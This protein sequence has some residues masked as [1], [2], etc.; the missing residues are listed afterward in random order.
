[1]TGAAGVRVG[2]VA[3]ATGAEFV[4]VVVAA[5]QHMSLCDAEG[6]AAA[7]AAATVVGE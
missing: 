1:M 2:M 7:A 5:V 4:L 3:G 6:R